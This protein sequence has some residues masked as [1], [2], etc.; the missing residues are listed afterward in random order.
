VRRLTV[1]SQ[2]RLEPIEGD[3]NPQTLA[4]SRKRT[5]S[6]N[7]IGL[8]GTSTRGLES[9]APSSHNTA[10]AVARY[11]LRAS[12]LSGSA[13]DTWQWY[14]TLNQIPLKRRLNLKSNDVTAAR[15]WK[16]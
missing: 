6:E 3:Y 16:T 14:R 5:N 11:R 15:V 2:A 4:R 13:S 12:Q 10:M 8:D 9:A 7:T 1:D